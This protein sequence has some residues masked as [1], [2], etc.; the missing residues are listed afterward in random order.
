MIQNCETYAGSFR[1]Y[2][3]GSLP[4]DD[5]AAML[6]HLQ[7]CADCQAKF[8]AQ[9]QVIS[10]LG[11]AYS[12]RR[13][14]EEFDQSA[15][16]KLMQL[17]R[18]PQPLPSATAVL[19]DGEEEA[20]LDGRDVESGSWR[21][22]L[23]AA[24]WWAVSVVLHGLVI[25]LAGLISMAIELP[26]NDDIM[27]TVTELSQRPVVAVEEEK[28]RQEEKS[29]LASKKETPPT[30]PT[31]LEQNQV[32][33]P[34]ELLA[35][36][37]LG[38][39]FETI[40]PDRPD[41]QSAFGNPDAQMF[42]S[43]KGSDE[44]EGGGGNAGFTLDDTIG[45]GGSSSPGSGGGWGG[46][47]GT[48]IGVGRGAGKGSFGNRGGGGRRLMVKKHGG[49]KATENAVDKALRW[50]AYHQEIDG[51]WDCDKHL[52]NKEWRWGGSAAQ[53]AQFDTGVSGLAMLAFLG[54]GHTLKIGEYRTNLQK[55]AA[56]MISQQ[57]E[58][59]DFTGKQ[60]PCNS[61]AKMYGH[62]I[63]TLAMAEALA[64]NNGKD[65]GEYTDKGA[66]G[67]LR[68]SV[69]KG[70]ALI[71][72]WQEDNNHGGWSYNFNGQD[73]AGPLDPTATGWA[74]M[75]LKAAKIAGVNIPAQSFQRATE[76]L[77]AVTHLDK[78]AGDYGS[79]IVGYRGK[80]AM[81]FNSK[82]YAC[83]AA[84]NVIWLFCGLPVTDDYVAAGTHFITT[85]DALPAW[86]FKPQDANTDHQ[87]LYYWYYG[88]LACFQAGGDHWKKW[89]KSM[90]DA[91]VPTQCQN[92]DDAG[93]WNPDDVWGA[94]G[95]RVYSTALGALCLEVYYRYQKISDK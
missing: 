29:A 21:D 80:A 46:G 42:H 89:N 67:S 26:Q 25:A 37:E 10:M 36:A 63:A 68:Q 74:V 8:D 5:A 93:S 70:I 19:E 7:G 57:S 71:L 91:L 16:R 64:M 62:C 75:A 24:P 48:G 59:G 52:S 4:A 14:S 1:R 38:D 18:K 49:S 3:E 86:N 32:I 17:H 31:S 43:E 35:K 27:V 15:D 45:V 66:G 78:A 23:S 55:A 61:A 11:Q 94:W 39:H 34:P 69:E 72:K 54:A 6:K 77:R 88:T 13:I 92:G 82:G 87:N 9:K 20:F 65:W 40:N 28:K 58:N 51:R 22:R 79:A 60:Q 84:G 81:P 76:S 56:W 83:T 85:P 44:P 30:D 41:T 95:G 73:M 50:L 2:I 33:V 90:I 53:S 12:S 47:D